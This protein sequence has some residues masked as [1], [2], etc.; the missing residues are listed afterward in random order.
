MPAYYRLFNGNIKD[1]K[2]VSLAIKESRYK[3]ALVIADKGFYSEDNLSILEA[4]VLKYII[5]LKRNSSLIYNELYGNLTQ[6]GNHFLFEDRVIYYTSYEITLTRTICLFTD[7][8]MMAKEKRDYVSRIG[9]YPQTYTEDKFKEKLNEFGTLSLITNTKE[10]PQNVY[11]N[12]KSRAGI[13]ILFDGLKNILGNDHTYMQDN[14]ALEGWMFVN[15]LALQVHHKIY[16][17]LKTKKLLH[18]YSIRD[19][20]EYL[21]DL[22][23]V[24]INNQWFLEELTSEHIKLIKETGIHI[25]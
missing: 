12:Y 21:S 2:M 1:V 24:K 19:F 20:I 7:E 4:E 15:H 16:S 14:N 13:E 18:K 25:P 6:T 10:T 3:D 9:T 22:K 11:L 8:L 17:F 5:P 23:K